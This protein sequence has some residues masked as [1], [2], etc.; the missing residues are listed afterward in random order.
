MSSGK[1]T[2]EAAVLKFSTAKDV[3][4]HV[5]KETKD[6]APKKL[7]ESRKKALTK[8]LRTKR[9]R[10]AFMTRCDNSRADV[11]RKLGLGA[12]RIGKFTKKCLET[13]EE[14]AECEKYVV[15]LGEGKPEK[16][17]AMPAKKTT[18]PKK[19]TKIDKKAEVTEVV[20]SDD[21]ESDEKK[22]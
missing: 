3:C 12:Q 16:K 20:P 10:D 7:S 21:S 1:K 22:K 2:A 4:D 15:A 18:K 9:I 6:L 11:Q 13:L 19:N 17:K 5:K 8:Q 14:I